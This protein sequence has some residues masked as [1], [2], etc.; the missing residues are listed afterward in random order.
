[1]R[2]FAKVLLLAGAGAFFLLAVISFVGANSA[3]DEATRWF[4]AATYQAE[5]SPGQPSAGLSGCESLRAETPDWPAGVPVTDRDVLLGSG[6]AVHST[7]SAV[8]SLAGLFLAAS[9]LLVG[10]VALVP[11]RRS[12]LSSPA[13]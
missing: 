10:V 13:T 2:T 8:L 4:A 11:G 1:M 6:A 12:R 3:Y 9:A 5:C 7:G